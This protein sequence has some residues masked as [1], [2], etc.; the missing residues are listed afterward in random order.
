MSSMTELFDARRGGV[1]GRWPRASESAQP[2]RRGS[3][4][5][6]R[7]LALAACLLCGPVTSVQAQ[8]DLTTGSP[9]D[10]AALQAQ[11]LHQLVEPDLVARLVQLTG[12]RLQQAEMAGPNPSL[13]ADGGFVYGIDFYQCSAAACPTTGDGPAAM[14]KLTRG[15]SICLSHGQRCPRQLVGP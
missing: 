12:H 11:S 14:A 10:S 1:K 5:A 4:A 6:V 8:Q 9:M 3:K 2:D 15:N 7:R 13:L